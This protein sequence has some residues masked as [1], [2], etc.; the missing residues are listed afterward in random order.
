M[1]KI[2]LEIDVPDGL[3][4]YDYVR[5]RKVFG[6]Y[7]RETIADCPYLEY[8]E[9][10]IGSGADYVYKERHICNL[11]RMTVFQVEAKK[12]TRT[13]KLPQCLN[14]EIKE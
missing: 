7:S 9:S 5:Y 13:I 2:R 10:T 8:K 11:F 6:G 3:F 14:A 1:A 4:C 12:I